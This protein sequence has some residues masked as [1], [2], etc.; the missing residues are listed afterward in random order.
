MESSRRYSVAEVDSRAPQVRHSSEWAVVGWPADLAKWRRQIHSG[1][2]LHR[3][4]ESLDCGP[5]RHLRVYDSSSSEGVLS[6]APRA[7]KF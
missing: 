2:Q 7:A 6:A 5:G 3:R 1:A 4:A